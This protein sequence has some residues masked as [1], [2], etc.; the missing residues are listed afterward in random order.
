MVSDKMFNRLKDHAKI[1][2]QDPSFKARYVGYSET[3]TATGRGCTTPLV[4]KLWDNSE[5]ERFLKRVQLKFTVSGIHMKNLDK[6]K[7]PEKLFPIENISFCN[8]DTTVNEKLFSWIC[9]DTENNM[10]K[11]H[12]AL[13]SSGEKAK[14][15]SLVMSRVFQ[16]AYKEWKSSQIKMRRQSEKHHRSQS[17]SALSLN[18]KR[19]EHRSL[20][21][22]QS[23]GP[24]LSNG[25]SSSSTDTELVA[26]RAATLVT[27]GTE[28]SRLSKEIG[29]QAHL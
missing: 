17:L 24:V 14:S 2:D 22:R 18:K 19:G 25:L 10:L 7:E 20:T 4:Q 13:C 23:A 1:T 3:F 16:I 28:D 26:R 6:K 11:C 27:T 15:M 5:D 29:E 9:L 12:V 8:V 21:A